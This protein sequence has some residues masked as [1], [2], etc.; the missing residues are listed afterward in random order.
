VDKITPLQ[1]RTLLVRLFAMVYLLVISKKNKLTLLLVAMMLTPLFFLAL[2][3]HMFTDL[4]QAM[5]Q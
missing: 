3:S 5:V 1:G 4:Y 2:V